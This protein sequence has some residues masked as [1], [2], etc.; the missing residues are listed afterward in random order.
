MIMEYLTALTNQ[1]K[2]K[3]QWIGIG[4]SW[5]IFLKQG[6][7]LKYLYPILFI[8][9]GLG[10]LLQSIE[11][12]FLVLIKKYFISFYDK[13][14]IRKNV[15]N[16]NSEEY[17]ILVGELLLRNKESYCTSTFGIE[18][19]NGIHEISIMQHMQN[20]RLGYITQVGNYDATFHINAYT[21]KQLRKIYM[22]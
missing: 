12:N 5:F 2:N 10:V 3:Y 6:Y 15:R 1:A 20:K 16:L 13:R 11:E 22:K 4:V 7:E 19:E 21:S 9:L 8:S 14:V 17:R 18:A